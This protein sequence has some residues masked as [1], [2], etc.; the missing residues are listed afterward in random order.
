MTLLL[1]NAIDCL[2]NARYLNLITLLAESDISSSLSPYGSYTTTKSWINNQSNIPI[3]CPENIDVV[4]YF[5]NNQVLARNWRVKFDAKA[6]VSV[7]TTLLHISPQ[8][9]KYFSSSIRMAVLKYA[10]Q[11]KTV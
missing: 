5:D 6:Q 8:T 2:Y 11:R 10:R 4:S 7:T 9:A 3:V 1:A